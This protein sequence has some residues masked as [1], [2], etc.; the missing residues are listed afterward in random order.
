MN[1]QKTSHVIEDMIRE[2]YK[3]SKPNNAYGKC[4]AVTWDKAFEIKA[5][6]IRQSKRFGRAY[7][8]VDN[9]EAF[10]KYSEQEAK[11]P[12]YIFVVYYVTED[13]PIIITCRI[14][15]WELVEHLKYGKES[16]QISTRLISLF[17]NVEEIL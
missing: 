3:L 11:T 7:I 16:F 9:H 12:Y 17:K 4:D 2:K 10:K 5:T 14:A 15:E 6:I 8:D 13:K 1:H